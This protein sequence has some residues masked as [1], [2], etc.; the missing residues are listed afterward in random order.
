METSVTIA[1]NRNRKSDSSKQLKIGRDRPAMV[2]HLKGSFYGLEMECDVTY[3]KVFDYS[4]ELLTNDWTGEY[5]T[6]HEMDSQDSCP[7][8]EVL[9][10]TPEMKKYGILATYDCS[11][12]KSGVEFVTKNP[13]PIKLMTKGTWMKSTLEGLVKTSGIGK[14]TQP[15]A[16]GLHINI[17]V[18][19][20]A[21]EHVIAYLCALNLCMFSHRMDR[22]RGRPIDLCIDGYDFHQDNAPREYE[23]YFEALT[24]HESGLETYDDFGKYPMYFGEIKQDSDYPLRLNDVLPQARD[25]PAGLRYNCPVIEVRGFQMDTDEALMKERIEMMEV[26]KV[27]SRD[28]CRT[29]VDIALGIKHSMPL[30]EMFMLVKSLMNTKLRKFRNYSKPDISPK[31]RISLTKVLQERIYDTT[32]IQQ[33]SII[34][35]EGTI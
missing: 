24:Q 3:N 1:I 35:P 31:A 13:V 25:Q 32:R 8:T 34:L 9:N 19:G 4:A 29:L 33:N 2:P 11:L 14:G 15:D 20:W 18:G 26:L 5:Q 6:F 12:Q 28:N 23:K 21:V 7:F 10:P 16:Y 27:A 30:E 17:N 22:L